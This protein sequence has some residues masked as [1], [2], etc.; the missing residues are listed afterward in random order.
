MTTMITISNGLLRNKP[1]NGTF[2]MKE[3]FREYGQ[4]EVKS[5]YARPDRDGYVRVRMDGHVSYIHVNRDQ[6]KIQA[7]D[8]SILEGGEPLARSRIGK[9]VYTG[10]MVTITPTGKETGTYTTHVVELR[11]D[12]A[13]WVD[14]ASG[15]RFHRDTGEPMIEPTGK[16]SYQSVNIHTVFKKV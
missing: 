15:E 16:K 13:F 6:I 2:E 11:K 5:G 10:E 1:V 8:E 4:S 9:T 3:K 12:G 14:V 7:I